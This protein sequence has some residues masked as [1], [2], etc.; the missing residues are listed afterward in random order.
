MKTFLF[1]LMLGVCAF[2]ATA[3]TKRTCT[4]Y[5]QQ[6]GLY[7]SSEHVTSTGYGLGVG[8][9]LGF[10]D[11]WLAQTDVNLHWING[12]A[13]STRF[14]GGYK[15]AGKWAPA[16]LAN[17]TVLWGS[18]TE[19]LLEDGRRPM[20][21]VPVFGLRLA[22]LRFENEK[23]FVSALE[24]GYGFGPYGGNCPELSLLVLGVRL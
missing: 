16:A 20:S 23:G 18:R 2:G 19:V 14:A 5:M 12:N 24:M 7:Y 13:I 10:G 22:P 9:A 3:Q 21:P 15:R 1:A 4:P 6:L 11:H 8:V 17:V